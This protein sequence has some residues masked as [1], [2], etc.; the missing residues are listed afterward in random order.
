VHIRHAPIEVKAEMQ[1]AVEKF[2]PPTQELAT[3]VSC[4]ERIHPDTEQMAEWFQEY[5]QS[6]NNRIIFG[7]KIV[8]E[9]CDKG[10]AIIEFGA[11]PLLLTASLARLGYSITGV[12]IAP[13]RFSR[14]INDLALE[15]VRCN[16]ET[17]RL[18]FHDSQFD[19][20]L[21]NE[22]FEHLR[23]NPI[24]TMREVHRILKPGG[25]LFL[26]TPKLRSLAGLANFLLRNRCYSCESDPYDE[27]SEL[28]GLGHM[29]HVREYTTREIT[30]FLGRI[31]FEVR[32]IVFRGTFGKPWA[33]ALCRLASPLRPFATYIGVKPRQA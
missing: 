10:A 6:Q 19:V 12:D 33:D 18:P 23:I 4:A 26:S 13:E 7:L 24:F 32:E 8:D 29:G 1:Y 5:V 30:E 2:D 31:G 22:L 28:E 14:A 17:E 21:F 16:I 9:H 25:L 11:V 3:V 27:F 15:V 20:A